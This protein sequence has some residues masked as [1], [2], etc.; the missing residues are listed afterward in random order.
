MLNGTVSSFPFVGFCKI[1]DRFSCHLILR[2]TILI[3]N[4]SEPKKVKYQWKYVHLLALLCLYSS[5][6][7]KLATEISES[8]KSY[9][10]ML[11]FL[12]YKF[13]HTIKQW[14]HCKTLIPV[15][16]KHSRV[17][18]TLPIHALS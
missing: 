6:E 14:P 2:I 9:W 10:S 12:N 8:M 1:L 15:A 7:V 4:P 5:P 11:Q 17:P 13:G 3:Q 16:S 18:R